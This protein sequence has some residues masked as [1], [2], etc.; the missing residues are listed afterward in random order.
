MSLVQNINIS[1]ISLKHLPRSLLWYLRSCKITMLELNFF[2]ETEINARGIFREF[3]NTPTENE[4]PDTLREW[5]VFKIQRSFWNL[6]QM[7]DAPDNFADY[8]A[9]KLTAYMKVNN[10]I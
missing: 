1:K 5:N 7:M 4:S 2:I 10:G 3:W 9:Q 6:I 8:Y